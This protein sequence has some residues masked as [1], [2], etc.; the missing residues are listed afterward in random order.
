MNKNCR[1]RLDEALEPLDVSRLAQETRFQRRKPKKLSPLVF[2]QSCCLLL[3]NQKV[4][5]RQW[6]MLIGTLINQTYAKQSL[7]ERMSASA[8]QFMQRVVL[9]LVGQLSLSPQ[10]VLPAALES[11]GRVLIQDST[12]LTLPAKL[13]RFFPGARNQHGSLGGM[14][15]VQ[16]LYDLKGRC[17]VHFSHGPFTRTD[18]DLADQVLDLLRPGDLLVR[19]LGYL[20]LA[21]LRRIDEL[22]AFFLSRFKHHLQVLEP[23]GQPLDLPALLHHR[24]RPFD[25]KVLVGGKEKLPVR[26]VAL[27]VPQEV[28]NRRRQQARRNRHY[29]PSK[30]HLRLLSW[31]LLITNVSRKQLPTRALAKA[32]GLRFHIETIFK[33][34]KSHFHLEDVP[35]GSRAQAETLL[36]ARLLL[37]TIFQVCF[38]GQWDY[39][40]QDR[41]GPLSLLKT[42]AFLQLYVPL[43]LLSELQSHLEAAL[44]KQVPY[45]CAYEKRRNRKNFMEKLELT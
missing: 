19:D 22:Q 45:H 5:L 17:F 24:T 42:A 4:S 21:V 39:E 6:A 32:Y 3:A 7:F 30:K 38:L 29:Q 31:D 14:L 18:Y 44:T 23:Q 8:A 37:I 10:R 1:S 34:W 27:R 25:K 36:Y 12:I 20:V 33:A 2:I 26:L 35:A 41:A 16:G 40:Y 11:F 9:G 28:A 15:R 43:T 13:R